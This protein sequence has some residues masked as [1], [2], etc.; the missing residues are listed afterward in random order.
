MVYALVMIISIAGA[1]TFK[2]PL[3]VQGFL[4]PAACNLA[5]IAVIGQLKVSNPGAS[6]QHVCVPNFTAP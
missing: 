5:A 4:S 6:E 2:P 3:V 1:G